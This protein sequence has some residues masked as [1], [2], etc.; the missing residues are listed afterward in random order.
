MSV[1]KYLRDTKLKTEE[2]E[3]GWNL[4]FNLA[5]HCMDQGDPNQGVLRYNPTKE[6][7]FG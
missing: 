1:H 4:I 7:L 2:K 3:T 5:D 6:L